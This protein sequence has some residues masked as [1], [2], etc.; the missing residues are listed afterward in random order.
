MSIK[1]GTDGWRAVLA[2][3]FTFKN[4]RVLSQSIAAYI[5]AQNLARKGLV[6]AYDQRFMAEDFALECARVL[7]GNGIRTYIM[8]RAAPTPLA[9]YAVQQLE[10]GGAIVITASHNPPEYCGMK[11]IPYYAGPALPDVTDILEQE[12]DR[13]E[14]GGRIYEL[15]LEEAEKLDLY[16]EVDLER[17][18]LDHLKRIL[19]PELFV[20]HTL[21]V[22]VDPMFGCG[23]GYLEKVLGELGCEVK[24][25]HNY[26]DPYF[27]GIRPDPSESNLA[28]LQR[29]VLNQQAEIGLAMDGDGDRFGII[30]KEGNFIS[31]NIFMA[32]VLEHLLQTRSFRGPVARNVATSHLLDR[33]ARRNGLPVIETPVGFKFLSQALRDRACMLAGEES[34]GLSIFGHVPEKD[35]ILACLLAVEMLVSSG[36]SL[37]AWQ[38]RLLEEYGSDVSRRFDLPLDPRVKETLPQLLAGFKP[39]NM[40]GQKVVSCV[41]DQGL[42]I[43][44]ENGSWVL[45][46]SSGTEEL[47]R[48]YVEAN[49]LGTLE[50]MRD[51]VLEGLNLQ[52]L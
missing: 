1:F 21:K 25:I 11:F 50:M 19:K 16:R 8:R 12:A 37:S 46:R 32:M 13:I 31:P 36:Q 39:R 28:A 33:V 51:E 52:V 23:I 18:Y 2:R 3:D 34:G 35:G 24:T 7:A 10:A 17:S 49:D 40:A 15:D 41:M 4:C 48:V 27:G 22:V 6:V 42:N 30:D 38:E 44:L 20:G 29:A 43:T 47:L 14:D 5:T 26:R 45:V 9:A